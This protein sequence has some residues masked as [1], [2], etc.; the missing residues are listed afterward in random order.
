MT[1]HLTM[2]LH[3]RTVTMCGKYAWHIGRKTDRVSRASCINC[4]KIHEGNQVVRLENVRDR[5]EVLEGAS[6]V[7][8]D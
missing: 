6:E 2:R 3:D 1:R 4:L 5:I 8:F 7:D